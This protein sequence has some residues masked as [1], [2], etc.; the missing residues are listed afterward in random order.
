M[1]LEAGRFEEHGSGILARA[2]TDCIT[3]WWRNG[4]GAKHTQKGHRYRRA[5]EAVKLAL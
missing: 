5:S 1:I 2:P 4:K 3:V